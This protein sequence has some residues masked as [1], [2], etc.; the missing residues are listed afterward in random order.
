MTLQE[1]HHMFQQQLA[2]I[3]NQT[4]DNNSVDISW[5]S[6]RHDLIKLART[7]GSRVHLPSL[8]KHLINDNDQPID[9]DTRLIVELLQTLDS[10][11]GNV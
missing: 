9:V 4:D 2:I 5:N 1:Q 10:I 11:K 3:L 7:E 8:E 6:Q